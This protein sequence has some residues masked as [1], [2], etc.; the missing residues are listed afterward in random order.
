MTV[1]TVSRRSWFYSAMGFAIAIIVAVGFARTYYL[2]AWLHPRPLTLRLHL[3]GLMLTSW[4]VL[5]LV[6]T[7]LIAASRITAH[8]RLGLA[9]AALAA[10]AVITTYAAAFESAAHVRGGLK[11]SIG[12]TAISCWS[13]CSVCSSQ[14][15]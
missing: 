2:K 5:F 9:G 14:Q 3:H 11:V 1:A 7:G 4:I 13:R 12:C 10:L 8:R 15:A 6:Q